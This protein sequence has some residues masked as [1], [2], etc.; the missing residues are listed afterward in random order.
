[1]TAHLARQGMGWLSG[2]SLPA[3]CDRRQVPH[4][5]LFVSSSV[6]MEKKTGR[7]P[8]RGEGPL[9]SPDSCGP[10]GGGEAPGSPGQVPPSRPWLQLLEGWGPVT[11][12]AAGKHT[13]QSS[14]PRAVPA[15]W[16]LG[17][18][19]THSDLWGLAEVRPCCSRPAFQ[20]LNEAL[21]PGTPEPPCWGG[22]RRGCAG[23]PRGE[24]G[25]QI[26]RRKEASSQPRLWV[27][28]AL[29]TYN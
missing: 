12:G 17:W 2:W 13:S 22:H 4:W 14:R 9:L 3:A 26:R 23:R 29:L 5:F 18:V 24:G 6:R 8:G 10:S 21:A 11:K 27:A 25:P 19:L 28:P 1:M 7:P 20:G 16:N 15:G